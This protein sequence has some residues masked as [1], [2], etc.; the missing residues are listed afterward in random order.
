MNDSTISKILDDSKNDNIHLQELHENMKSKLMAKRR[1]RRESRKS[2]QGK[3]TFLVN[4]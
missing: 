2:L 1:Q 4:N 3:K